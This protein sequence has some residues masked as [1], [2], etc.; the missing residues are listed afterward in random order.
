MISAS[1]GTRK[2]LP[3]LTEGASRSGSPRNAPTV[4]YSLV[5]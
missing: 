2:S 3:Q 5:P 4:A 1:A